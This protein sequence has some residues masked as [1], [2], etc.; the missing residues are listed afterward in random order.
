MSVDLS[1]S[2]L[3]SKDKDE[4]TQIAQ[5]MGGKPSSRARKAEIIDLIIELAQTGDDDSDGGD[6]DAEP[7]SAAGNTPAYSADPMADA[8]AAEERE[9]GG[10]K[11]KREGT[12]GRRDRGKDRSGSQGSGSE[13]SNGEASEGQNNGE[14]RSG[15]QPEPGNRRRRR[16]GRNRDRA[17]Q[18][19]DFAG[20]PVDVE[21]VLDLRDDGY[22]FLRVNGYLPTRDDVYVSVKQVRQHGLRRGDHLAGAGRPANRSEKNPAMVRVDA[23]NGRDPESAPERPTFDEL[24]A[25]LPTEKLVLE[26]EDDP[27]NLTARM[28][29]LLAPIG[30]GQRGLVVAPPAAG[31]TTALTDIARSI[32][33]NH[34]DVRLMVCLID[35]R[36]EEVTQ[37]ERLILNG[38]VVTSTFEQ[39]GDEHA[40]VAELTLERAK[41]LV[42]LGEDVVVIFD[43]VTR[44]TRALNLAAAGNGQVQAGGLTAS[45]LYPAKRFFGAARNVED[46]GS[47]TVIASA[48]VDSGSPIDALILD[49][50]TG[51][52]NMELWLDRDA[53]ARRVYPAIDVLA[54]TTRNEDRLF[55]DAELA[56]V[57]N[58]RQLL[59]A[60]RDEGPDVAGL[61]LLIDRMRSTDNNADLLKAVQ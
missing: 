13:Q 38:D 49:E 40:S 12:N 34:P 18:G 27:E 55:D 2:K 36:P 28:I 44:L 43:G 59:A 29:D 26:R 21:G 5:A 15:D 60:A 31:R 45:A 37:V 42:E 14:D 35:E 48:Q 53:A 58:L 3:A 6:S 32:E 1:K 56:Q 51:T 54:S 46:G 8:R 11:S 30:K 20:D 52:A 47:L 7:A 22:G 57:A 33:T 25:V 19:E 23:I 24:K 50:F 17:D 41:R 9:H 10:S 39:P 61:Q 4:L 16:R